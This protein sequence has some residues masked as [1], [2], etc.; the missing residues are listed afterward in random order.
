MPAKKTN[1][2]KKEM[3][4]S[5]FFREGYSKYGPDESFEFH[6]L[7]NLRKVTL[8][9]GEVRNLK[10]S[11]H[12]GSKARLLEF[13]VMK[14]LLEITSSNSRLFELFPKTIGICYA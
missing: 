4:H 7:L 2:A 1:R 10:L 12:A 8:S 14:I 13:L 3:S 6:W 11:S 5:A 9:M